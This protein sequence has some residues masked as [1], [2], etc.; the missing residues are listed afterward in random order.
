MKTILVPTGGSDT[1]EPVFSTALA[2]ARLLN[3]HL[4]FFHV[5]IGPDEAARYMPHVEHARG[6]AI[7]DAM[8]RLGHEAAAR[9]AAAAG[10]FHAFC[11][12]AKIT[13]VDKP[14]GA[15]AVTASWREE[16]ND[17]VSRLMLRARHNDLVVLGRAAAPNGLPP[18]F[19][20]TLM[21][22]C[23]RPVLIAAAK[24]PRQSIGTVMVCWKETPEAA[25]AVTAAMPLL[26]RAE[27]VVF[28]AVTEDEQGLGEALTDIARQMEWH[29]VRAEAQ[30]KA[31]DG[32]AIAEQLASSA[33]ACHAD[34]MVMGAYGHARVREL[35]FGG[36]TQSV[37][38][39][40]DVPVF[41]LY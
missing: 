28:V 29:G 11:A 25:R 21:L 13:M 2:A 27:R 5:R 37:L 26:V 30:L 15:T 41:I 9:S 6:P 40:A 19:L 17:A 33:A 39:Y 1:D 7:A 22:G 34:L 36:C 14:H 23:G 18:A 35:I 12:G 38:D 4:E 32:R 31:S 24:A 8:S 20:E 3:A 16:K 10:H